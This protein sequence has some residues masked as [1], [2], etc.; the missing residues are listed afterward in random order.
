MDIPGTNI[1]EDFQQFITKLENMILIGMF[2]PRERLVENDLAQKMG[3]RR[4]WVRD[5]L[6]ILE[7]KGLIKTVPYR[8]AMVRDLDE[9]KINE[10]FQVRVVLERLANRLAGENFKKPDGK[11]LR[12]IADQINDSYKRNNFEE[13]MAAN[14]QFHNYITELS[15]NSTLIQM[16]NE[17]RIRFHIFNTFA[18]SSPEIVDLLSKEHDQFITGLAKKDTKLLDDLAEKHFSHSKNLYLN[19]LRARRKL[20]QTPLNRN[21][22][23]NNGI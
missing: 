14:V 23:K 15:N 11:A 3:V 19:H 22:S 18:W 17:L 1:K 20:S 7:S 5:A 6:K 9:Q 4:N 8:G 10:I 21:T 13:M 16:I 2:Q 12:K